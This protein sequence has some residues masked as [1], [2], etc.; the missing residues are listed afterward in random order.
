[1]HLLDL[2]WLASA[3]I[4]GSFRPISETNLIILVGVTG[5]GKTTTVKALRAADIPF[6][7]LP[8]R[9]TLTDEL[10]I[11]NLQQMDGKPV[12]RVADRSDRFALTRRYRELH[13]GGMAH[14]L[15][16][17]WVRNNQPLIFDGLRGVNEIEFAVSAL[18]KANFLVLDAPHFVRLRRLLGRA[19]AFDEVATQT[20]TTSRNIIQ[21]SDLGLEFE[22]EGIDRLFSSEEDAQLIRLVNSGRLAPDDLAAKLKIVLAERA[23]YDPAATIEALQRLARSRSWLYD[24]DTLSP[25]EIALQVKKKVDALGSNN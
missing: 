24:T 19:D 18:P 13:P 1:M 3:Q 16:K 22:S 6:D 15:T 7:L 5:V 23:N 10:I 17:L 21:L 14:A 12:E 25:K 2:D 20:Q 9:R 11:A 8:N 4:D